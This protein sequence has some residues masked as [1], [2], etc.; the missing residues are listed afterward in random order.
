MNKIFLELKK[1]PR[2]WYE[3][4]KKAKV[5][6]LEV[7]FGFSVGIFF[8]AI[9]LPIINILLILAAIALLRINKLAVILGYLT[10]LWPTTPFIYYI[11][12]KLGLFLSGQNVVL[13]V[14]EMS[15]QLIKKYIIIFAIGNFLF[16]AAI[17]GASFF[18]I[19]GVWKGIQLARWGRKKFLPP[20]NKAK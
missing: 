5:T 11:S 12:L 6:P 15:F 1:G 10:L 17:A 8:S 13:S 2:Y 9:A 3:E 16:A 4:V 7:A 18:I 19:Y 20:N 14:S